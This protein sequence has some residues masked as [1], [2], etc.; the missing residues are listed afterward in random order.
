MK[1]SAWIILLI[2][3]CSTLLQAQTFKMPKADRPTQKLYS[4]DQV[5]KPVLPISIP[6]AKS[7]WMGSLSPDFQALTTPVLPQKGAG[8]F[9]YQTDP[10]TG[11]PILIQGRVEP[12]KLGQTEN[13]SDKALV[14]LAEVSELMQVDKA[15]ENFESLQTWTDEL[16]MEHVKLQQTH[17]G[18][19][20]YGAEV[21]VHLKGGQPEFLNGRYYPTPQ[22][23]LV[24]SA[25]PAAG[26]AEL[27]KQ[28][29]SATVPF[30]EI[31]ASQQY[32]LDG[33]QVVSELVIYHPDRDAAAERL[34]WHFT[35]L[36]NLMDR[37]EYF[38][39]AH[40]GEVIHHFRNSCRFHAE[41]LRGKLA[42]AS[43][44]PPGPATANATDL[45]GQTVNIKVYELGGTYYMID[46][47][48]PMYNGGASDLP[49]NPVGAIWTIDAQSQAPNNDGTL[50]IIQ[51]T[52]G[53]NN[54]NNQKAVSAHNHA[55][56]SYEYFL[57][58]F[59]RNSI[60][61]SGGT[62]ISIINVTEDG[63]GLDNA[64]WNGQAMFYGNGDFAFNAPLCK[65]LDVGGHE[66][67]HGVIE[68]TANLEYQNQSGALNESYAD[69]FGAM[70]DRDDWK[71]GE[72][73]VNPSVFPSGA[74]RDL[75][76][77]NNGGTG[78]NSNGWQPKHMN[79]FQ[80]LP[81][82]AQ[83]DW[84]G[85]HVN[86]GIPNHAF[87]KFATAIGKD[88]AEDVFY[89]AL[90]NYLVKSS[91]FIDCRIAV[92][93]SAKDLYGNSSSEATAAATAFDE[94]GIGAGQ[95]GDYQN[96]IPTN[97]GD[98]YIVHTDDFYDGLYISN[99]DGSGTEQV[100]FASPISRPS[101]TDDG[102]VI[103]Y[104]GSDA[105]M[106]GIVFDWST[107]TYDEFVVQ[108]EAIWRNVA[109]SKDGDR[110]AALTDDY[111]NE[112][113]IYD[114]GKEEW[115][116]YELYNPTYATGVTTG[117]VQ[118]ADV[119][120]WDYSNQYVLYDAYNEIGSG[121]TSIPYWDVGFLRVWNLTSDNWSDG[122]VEKLFTS[123]PDG[124]SIG[125]PAFAKNSPYIV[126]F[127]YFV[128]DFFGEEYYLLAANIETVDV[129][130]IYQNLGLSWPIYST[131]DNKIIFDAESQ[132]GDLIIAEISLQADKITPVP[133]SAFILIEPGRWGVWF[134]T[135]VR[136]QVS[137]EEV[138]LPEGSVLVFPN[139]ADEAVQVKL[140]LEDIQDVDLRLLDVSGRTV[141]VRSLAGA[142]GSLTEE[143]D[144]SQ[145]QPGIYFLHTRIGSSFGITK[146]IVN[147]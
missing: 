133:N 142:A 37:Y 2:A 1:K 15:G 80:N 86:S 33:P 117:N 113:W 146:L 125:N 85:V 96:D 79:E 120:E 82:T 99:T 112:V 26:A 89:R 115:V 118:Y 81:N 63:S 129:G 45:L 101:V 41:H 108:N 8:H 137:T 46:A 105:R 131:D 75:S 91:Q 9:L 88:K 43:L 38:V 97:P 93:Q 62:I 98:E 130:T 29:L 34:V 39:D 127:D 56:K 76:N 27:A 141:L 122:N 22:I 30:Q 17:L 19:P 78:P 52:S 18:I 128:N 68:N 83:G 138:L 69:I 136:Q 145:V 35:L 7:P 107:G 106:Y 36:P 147:E 66:M 74:L 73:I 132:S 23:S 104:I 102:S 116:V 114:F 60:N 71:M 70:I 14:Y 143:L 24:E 13:T 47:S 61:G 4:P 3:A 121:A 59:N 53:N 109:I 144:L 92:I 134:A 139:P 87:Y 21:I 11:L 51:V 25:I 123:L 55:A 57:G 32:L 42:E 135:G 100:S 94:V 10:A 6:R 28:H 58:T 140:D 103:L 54:W 90:D 65:A 44:L 20:V 77:P 64:F 110:L 67:S 48:R 126:A 16:G 50:N 124:V 95:G 111:T 12:E 84:G 119:L 5:A 49:D 40:S 31:P 72:N